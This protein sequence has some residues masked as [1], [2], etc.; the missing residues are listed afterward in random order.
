MVDTVMV[1]CRLFWLQVIGWIFADVQDEFEQKRMPDPSLAFETCAS[2]S[3][4]C[5]PLFKEGTCDIVDQPVPSFC[6]CA[7]ASLS[8]P[9]ATFS[10]H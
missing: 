7:L 10:W 3:G 5:V 6:E 2:T 1:V 4:S 9:F 8:L